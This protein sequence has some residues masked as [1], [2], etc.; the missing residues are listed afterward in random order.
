MHCFLGHGVVHE[1]H[2]DFVFNTAAFSGKHISDSADFCL[3]YTYILSMLSVTSL[4]HK[5]Y[6]LYYFHP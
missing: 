5:T 2:F 3:T 6:A 1:H 4:L